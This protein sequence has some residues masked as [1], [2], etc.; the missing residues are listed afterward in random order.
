MSGKVQLF[1]DAPIHGPYQQKW[2]EHWLR[3]V[4]EA[5]KWVR[6]NGP[7][8]VKDIELIREEELHEIQRLWGC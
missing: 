6:E 1:Y 8:H 4:L 5:Q 7:D 2:R 3:R